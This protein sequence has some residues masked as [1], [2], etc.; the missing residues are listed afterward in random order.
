MQ[1]L[2]PF[3]LI[4]SGL[5]NCLYYVKRKYIKYVLYIYFL[6]LLA[7]SQQQQNVKLCFTQPLMMP[8][9][10]AT[11]ARPVHLYQSPPCRTGSGQSQSMNDKQQGGLL[12]LFLF[13][14]FVFFFFFNT[15]KGDQ[16]GC[17]LQRLFNGSFYLFIYCL[18][19]FQYELYP[20]CLPLQPMPRGGLNQPLVGSLCTFCLQPR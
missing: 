7:S 13:F 3:C 18:E 19:S 9:R 11:I 10:C 15:W 1:E 14:C 17:N 12:L 6:T 2:I 4:L 8:R 20:G 16:L 5:E